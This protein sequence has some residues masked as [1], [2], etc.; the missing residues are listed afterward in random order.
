MEDERDFSYFAAEHG[1][2]GYVTEIL[3]PIVSVVGIPTVRLNELVIFEN[4]EMGQVFALREDTVQVGLLARHPVPPATRVARTGQM[5]SFTA[6]PELGGK[7][8]DPLGNIVLG[9][10]VK[11]TQTEVL[12]VFTEA[13][14]LAQRRRVKVQM[15]SG[16][17]LVDF[18][19]P[20][21]RGQKQ[22]LIGDRK[23]GKRQFALQS[24]LTAVRNGMKVVYA[25]I[26][27]NNSDIRLI[28]DFF[29][30]E[31]IL[32]YVVII[33]TS[34][35]DSPA[36]IYLT[37]YVAMTAAE[38][39]KKQG[40]DTLVILEDISTHSQFYREFSLLAGRFPGRESYP[41][42][43]FYAHSQLLERA[44]NFAFTDERDVSITCMPIVHIIEGDFTSYIS[45]NS[46]GMTDGHLF[47]D[48]DTFLSGIR[49]PI[50]I[51]LSV[52]R[53]GK[54]TQVPLLR[55]VNHMITSF[56]S[57]YTHVQA[58]SRFG[59]EVSATIRTTLTRGQRMYDFFYQNNYYSSSILADLLLFSLV[60]M[61]IFNTKTGVDIEKARIHL[62]SELGDEQTTNEFQSIL[63][64]NDADHMLTFVSERK[65][66]LLA[67][68]GLKT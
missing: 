32:D 24:A 37:P 10:S 2:T 61:D 36:L 41:G 38:Y 60:W 8:I 15:T 51:S 56:F 53:A 49:P 6:Y 11:P 27:Q 18:L 25:A 39:Y 29:E 59:A 31:G 44:G 42:D 9:E 28:Y 23:T 16:I 4:G 47:F 3:Y 65:E 19:L 52:T 58:Y 26:G 34:S 43:I 30:S 62:M 48:R 22:L 45:T 50:N 13:P 7:I 64:L 46:I 33:A 21:G 14:L 20:I 35:V 54:Q 68:C 17:R 12:P 67:L 5:V 55:D 63:E 57:E 66:R 40:I 1:E